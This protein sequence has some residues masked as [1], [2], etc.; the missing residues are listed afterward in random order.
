[1]N[2]R[3]RTSGLGAGLRTEPST[4]SAWPLV[5]SE[6]M[7]VVGVPRDLSTAVG[8]VEEFDG[9]DDV[10]T[11]ERQEAWARL[12]R[13][14]QQL[15]LAMLVART[16]LLR[17][18]TASA[19]PETQARA[20]EIIGRYP[21][22]AKR[23]APGHVNG[24]QKTHA[25]MHGLWDTDARGYWEE[26]F[27][28]L[29]DE[30]EVRPASA[31]SKKKPKR[32]ASNADAVPNI[33]DTWPLWSQVRGQKA[34]VVGGTPNEASRERLERAFQFASLDWSSIDGPRRVDALAG[35]IEMGAY[36]LVLVLAGYVAHKESGHII[37]AAKSANVPC[38]VVDG[39]YGVAAVRAGM[40]RFLGT[41][42]RAE[43]T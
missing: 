37:E 43:G 24:M 8:V 30:L 28:L 11:P 23:Y 33:E 29:G 21:P 4:S 25:P 36:G 32:A 1:M 12:P 2:S 22:W 16:R 40:D 6:L 13:Q 14:V 31:S 15:W 17:E 27:E 10:A 7:A 38:V 26:L 20:K 34:I 3:V 35:R 9:L 19:A 39:G 18:R 5:L 42:R 41:A